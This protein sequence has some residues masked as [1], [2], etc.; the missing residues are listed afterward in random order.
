[1]LTTFRQSIVLWA[2][3]RIGLRMTECQGGNK[4]IRTRDYNEGWVSR[5]P[6]DLTLLWPTSTGSRHGIVIEVERLASCLAWPDSG[7]QRMLMTTISRCR[8]I[9]CHCCP[10]GDRSGL[11]LAKFHYPGWTSIREVEGVTKTP[12]C[13]R[14]MRVVEHLPRSPAVL[15]AAESVTND[16]SVKCLAINRPYV[17]ID[18]NAIVSAW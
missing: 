8:L 5:R 17:I 14:W 15:P 3:V 12:S 7:T 1:M 16:S 11:C 13:R 9:T 10:G 2:S 18:A 4:G 6:V